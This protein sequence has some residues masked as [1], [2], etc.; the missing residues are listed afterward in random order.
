[1]EVLELHRALLSIINIVRQLDEY[2][3]FT[4]ADKMTVL[5]GLRTGNWWWS[6]KSASS[7]APMTYLGF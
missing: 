5:G 2:R 3:V 1:M 7:L 6:D 4:K